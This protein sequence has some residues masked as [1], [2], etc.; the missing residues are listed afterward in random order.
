[1]SAW[2]QTFLEKEFFK[3]C[4]TH[5]LSNNETTMYCIDCDLPIC[6]HCFSPSGSCGGH[7]TIRIYRHVYQDAV[8]GKDLKKLIDCSK[9][10]LYKCNK[11][12]VATLHPL[13]N[14]IK[15]QE[16]TETSSN[17]DICKRSLH[18]P[19]AYRY[20]SLEC[21]VKAISRKEKITDHPFLNLGTAAAADRDS[22]EA[23]G[24]RD[25]VAADSMLTTVERK[26]KRKGVPHRA[27]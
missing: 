10:Q 15:V 16:V 2:L 1:M 9:I 20:C 13:D 5:N 7:K 24:T 22:A 26:K 6:K 18:N 8:V 23:A 11:K 19:A 12:R 14:K 3:S 17:C 25:T 27:I 21:K 4:S